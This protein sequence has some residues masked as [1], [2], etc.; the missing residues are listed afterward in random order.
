M[1]QAEL[2]E[3]TERS[4]IPEKKVSWAELFFDLVFVFAVTQISALLHD[5]HDWVGVAQALVV[6]VPIWW[7]WVGTSVH[8]NTHDVENAVDRLGIFAIGLGS[9]FMSLA[10]PQAYGDRGLLFGAAYFVLR[11]LLAA[12]YFRTRPFGLNAFSVALV[13][14][15]PMLLVG[16]LLPGG[17]RIAVWALAGLIDL[18]VPALT[19]RRLAR[20][21]FDPSHLPERFGLFLI[22]TLG[23]SIIA[24]GA[25][26]A[27]DA[28]TVGR[29]FAVAAAFVVAC[30]LW[31]VYF[32]FAASAVRHAIAAAR[33]QTDLIRQVLA[34]GHLPLIGGIIAIAV[35]MAE[36][37][38]H[39]DHHLSVSVAALLVGGCA[40]Y[41]ATFGYTRWRMYRTVAW[42]RLGGAAVCLALL[43]V[44]SHLPALA[45]LVALAVVLVTLNAL[46]AWAV[47][48]AGAGEPADFLERRATPASPIPGP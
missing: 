43:P 40:L 28:L 32:V 17:A 3:A 8:A 14:T 45:V 48:R 13:V 30:G 44:A 20:V 15:G 2:S 6:F 26:A 39:P 18:A 29:A 37:V 10:I 25:S 11:M 33:V 19:R 16:G 34:Y 38:A 47:R 24:I 41:L 4:E 1:A 42:P 23:E 27:G 7:A 22:L 5:R 12:V 36:V 35:G 46:E 31:W 9:L 21:R